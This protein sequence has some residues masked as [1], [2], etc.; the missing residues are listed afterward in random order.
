MVYYGTGYKK[1]HGILLV[2]LMY[3]LFLYHILYLM[4]SKHRFPHLIQS[5]IKQ[6]IK[7]NKQE[8]I[9]PK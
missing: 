7:I 5:G 8:N 4:R 3:S 6:G 1:S 9:N 2:C